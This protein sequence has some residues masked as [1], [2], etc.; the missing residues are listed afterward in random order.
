[1]NSVIDQGA[2]NKLR[3][4]ADFA[5]AK[6]EQTELSPGHRKDSLRNESDFAAVYV[7][8]T[9]DKKANNNANRE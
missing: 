3:I 1:M 5:A 9:S 6:R 2:Q 8:N 4:S 7:E